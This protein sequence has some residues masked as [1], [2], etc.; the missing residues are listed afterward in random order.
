MGKSLFPLIWLKLLPLCL[1]G[2]HALAS[3]IHLSRDGRLAPDYN[4]RIDH[5]QPQDQIKIG[6]QAFRLRG[7]LGSGAMTYVWDVGGGMVVRLPKAYRPQSC[8]NV[9]LF[10]FGGFGPPMDLPAIT[11]DAYGRYLQGWLDAASELAALDLPVVRAYPEQSQP[12]LYVVAERLDELTN[13]QNWFSSGD[14]ANKQ[15]MAD[16]EAFLAKLEPVAEIGDLKL[17][18]I[19]YVR[20][21]GWVLV[22]FMVPIRL[23]RPGET[24]GVVEA[25][26]RSSLDARASR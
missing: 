1:V 14:T 6:D 12:P 8:E 15:M 2:G 13:A 20:S 10:D 19:L 26:K 22:D 23:K 17:D 3:E 9:I 18:S 21:R 24:T 4:S 16:W 7:K 11:G 25:L 5:L